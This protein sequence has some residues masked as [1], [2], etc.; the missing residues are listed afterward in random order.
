[1]IG[2]EYIYGFKKK[3]TGQFYGVDANMQLTLSS[4]PY[5]LKY[6][7][8]GW[9]DISVQNKRNRKYFGLDRSFTIPLAFVEDGAAILKNVFY[10]QGTEADIILVICEQQLYISDTEYGFW[11][12]LL[13]TGE[14]DLTTW[15]HN[16]PRVNVT[17]LEEGITKYIKANENTTYE[18]PLNVPEAI[19]IKNDGISIIQK[20]QWYISNGTVSNDL[21]GHCL[22][23]QLV[24]SEAVDAVSATSQD[25]IKEG[26]TPQKLWDMNQIVLTT[27][28][29]PE[30]FVFTWDFYMTP[31][32]ESVG[33]IFATSIILQ[34]CVLTDRDT[35]NTYS[36]DIKGGGDPLLLYNIKQHFHGTYTITIPPN[37]R[38]MFYMTANQNRDFTYYTYD[39][40]GS[41][42]ADYKYKYQDTVTRALRPGYVFSKLIE[43]IS[44]N[45]FTVDT[46]GLLTDEETKVFSSGD[47][48]RGFD[49][50]VV[51]I[52]LSDFHGFWDTYKDAGI[53]LTPA[54]KVKMDRKIDLIDTTSVIDL[55][56]VAEL[57]VSS[58]KEF[59]FN[60]LKIGY[61]DK[62]QEDLNG[63]EAFNN[64]FEWSAGA[65]RESK[66]LNK[67]CKIITD[68]Y[69]AELTRL[70]FGQRTTTDSKQ[71]SGV[72]CFHIEA[73]PQL[74][75]SYK[76]DRSI[77]STAIGLIEKDSVYNIEL[78]P[79][80]C[81]LNNGSY[82]ISCFDLMESKYFT[83]QTSSKN[84][85]LQSGNILIAERENVLISTLGTKYFRPYWFEFE[86]QGDLDLLDHLNVNPLSIFKFNF[87]GSEFFG[88]PESV[89][90]EPSSRKKQVYKLL[91]S[92][93]TDL[94]AL[95]D[96]YG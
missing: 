46:A 55:G 95:I 6:N 54:G 96:Y 65:L 14:V 92:P 84:N 82:F 7:P 19:E 21:G 75:G 73:A 29:S 41:M 47:G 12:K 53:I 45:Q 1:M 44:E 11:Y 33:A 60:N 39:D 58:A 8:D 85:K 22:S 57:K 69:S 2:N 40:D 67:V 17:I 28:A 25:R 61:P 80:R 78:S 15:L 26:N 88:L 36:L 70:R 63:R 89:G 62:Q 66:E 50:A 24:S 49:D 59:L 83:F 90:I 86:T 38:V 10:K 31:V 23:M 34:L 76:F 51:K 79:K 3:S 64:T 37:K 9:K 30:S 74:D 5:F 56:T 42:L 35:A 20:G 94:K 4:T 52:S 43:S 87:K 93:N 71:D 81:L 16:G 77:N 13:Y 27:G 68:C 72:Y 48:I 18:L 32:L 91:C